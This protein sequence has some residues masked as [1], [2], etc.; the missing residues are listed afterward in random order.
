MK[1]AR[2]DQTCAVGAAIFGAVAAGKQAG[3][4]KNTAEAQAAICGVRSKVFKPIA[5][6]HKVYMVMYKLY[7]ELHDA[8]GT[9]QWSGKLDNVMKES[10]RNQRETEK[11]KGTTDYTDSTD[12]EEQNIDIRVIREICG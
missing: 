4:F 7:R 9:K 3:G 8:F 1:I 12:T 6:N 10:H 2:S 11:L 5:A